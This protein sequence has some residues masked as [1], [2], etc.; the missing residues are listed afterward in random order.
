MP[1]SFGIT[2]A[3][4][5]SFGS[6]AVKSMWYGNTKFYPSGSTNYIYLGETGTTMS[7]ASTTAY[8]AVTAST[9]SWTV[10]SSQSWITVSKT[11]S[12]Q[13]QFTVSSNKGATLRNGTIYFKIGGTVY[14]TYDV[15]Q[16]GRRYVFSRLT[17]T[18][19]N[20][21]YADT[22][23]FIDITSTRDGYSLRPLLSIT[24]NQ[25]GVSLHELTGGNGI[26][27]YEFYCS[28]NVTTNRRTTTIT[29]TQ[30]ESQNTLVYT[31]SQS[32]KAQVYP[33]SGFTINRTYGDWALGTYVGTYMDIGSY[34]HVPIKS[35]AIIRE[36]IPT[37]EYTA[38]YELQYN[39]G[40]PP[41]STLKAQGT[42]T[43]TSGNVINIPSGGT[44]YGITVG[45]GPNAY[46]T[47]V[48]GFTVT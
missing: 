36:A 47:T 28:G 1:L 8:V 21:D 31:V 25:V 3:R 6:A 10:E 45:G 5:V 48:S 44:G 40:A 20:I 18:P 23:F 41:T 32:G 38:D 26:W 37:R 19:V 29:F 33:V 43:I 7:T 30:P 34:T 4:S 35:V 27:S 14:A 17:Q 13:A 11:N 39:Y 42:R 15:T 2:N 24:D 22:K 9:S 46:I 16:E 12:T